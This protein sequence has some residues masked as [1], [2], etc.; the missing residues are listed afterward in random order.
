M[1]FPFGEKSTHFSFNTQ[2][3]FRCFSPLDVKP[4][5]PLPFTQEWTSCPY[6]SRPLAIPRYILYFPTP[7]S[8][9][10]LF[11]WQGCLST[12]YNPANIW[13][14]SPSQVFSDPLVRSFCLTSHWAYFP[15]PCN[16]FFRFPEDNSWNP[17]NYLINRAKT[18]IRVWR[19]WWKGSS[20]INLPA[21]YCSPIG[22][23]P[24]WRLGVDWI[25]GKL[26]SAVGDQV[27]PAKGKPLLHFIR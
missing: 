24:S 2:P 25:D 26:G 19:T 5:L 27:S 15:R 7:V 21:I 4:L 8:L 14:L 12:Y 20:T 6:Q 22:K 3:C 18:V 13:F 10:V 11:H 17:R 9:L 16:D 1:W 23:L